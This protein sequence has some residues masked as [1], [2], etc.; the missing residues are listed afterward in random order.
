MDRKDFKKKIL[1][2][3]VNHFRNHPSPY[4]AISKI[5][6]SERYSIPLDDVEKSIDFL[7]KKRFISYALI[8]GKL[9]RD[10]YIRNLGVKVRDLFK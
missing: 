7:K 4:D 10:R 9:D 3:I 1:K 2:K 6:L 5:S 8:N